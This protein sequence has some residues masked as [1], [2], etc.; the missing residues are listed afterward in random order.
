MNNS[1]I[2]NIIDRA[3][4]LQAKKLEK[5]AF[6]INLLVTICIS[7]AFIYGYLILKNEIYFVLLFVFPLT[8]YAMYLAKIGST[9][10]SFSI[11]F[12]STSALIAVFSVIQGEEAATHFH[13][14][15]TIIA[16]S[17]LFGYDKAKKHFYYNLSFTI[18]CIALVLLSFENDWFNQFRKTEYNIEGVRFLNYML[19]IPVTIVYSFIV[20]QNSKTQQRELR[21]S[22]E[23]QKTL[24]AEVNHRVK[25]NMAI[26]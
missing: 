14:V 24:L 17:L 13:F 16:L 4:E 23:E 21:Y 20:V 8:A 18:I 15:N 10:P 12:F 1:Q 11:M 22:L 19:I 26:I 7:L 6:L 3:S 2:S 25:N 9:I 5:I